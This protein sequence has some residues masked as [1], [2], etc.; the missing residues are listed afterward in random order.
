MGDR[1]LK[2]TGIASVVFTIG[3]ALHAFVI[4]NEQTLQRMFEL[5]NAAPQPGFLTAFRI[6]GCVYVAGNAIGILALKGKPRTWLFWVVI[7]VNA[8]QAAGV[9]MVPP[10]MWTAVLDEFGLVGT[11]PSLVTDGG[12]LVLTLIL[13]ITAV[14]RKSVWAQ[15]KPARQHAERA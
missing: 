10:E 12:A 6:V 9:R 11:L 15:K 8:T 4:I 5:A 13:V 2:I 1:L 3:T 14:A 7:A